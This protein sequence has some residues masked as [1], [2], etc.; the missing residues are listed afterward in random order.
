[1]GITL[2]QIGPLDH[3]KH[4]RTTFTCG[5]AALD[6]FLREKARKESPE[7]SATFVLTCVEKPSLVLGYYSLS[8]AALRADDLPENVRKKFGHYGHVPATLLGRLA[9]HEQYQRLPDMRL[10]ELLLISAMSK[11][12]S[13]SKNVA[14]FGIIVRVLRGEKGDPTAFYEKYGFFR[15]EETADLMFLPLK[16]IEQSLKAA[17]LV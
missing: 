14:S 6:T 13:A 5:V 11:S 15:C 16:T 8:A 4:D 12:Y 10:G 2:N 17:G 3:K 9:V 1:M 7:L